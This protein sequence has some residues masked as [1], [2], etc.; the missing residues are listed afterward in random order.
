MKLRT[1]SREVCIIPF[2]AVVLMKNQRRLLNH[3]I[4]PRFISFRF[5]SICVWPNHS[6]GQKLQSQLHHFF[7]QV[8][9]YAVW[10]KSLTVLCSQNKTIEPS[11]ER[12]FAFHS[13]FYDFASTQGSGNIV[14]FWG[15]DKCVEGWSKWILEEDNGD[16]D[17]VDAELQNCR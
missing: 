9:Y 17:D 1:I 3:P 8:P 10:A 6:A 5:S 13:I 2:V 7:F 14:N 12:F 4:M 15:T 16:D 11:T